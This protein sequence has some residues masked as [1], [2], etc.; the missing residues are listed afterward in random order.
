VVERRTMRYF[1]SVLFYGAVIVCC[2]P[3]LSAQTLVGNQPPRALS[4]CEVLESLSRHDRRMVVV[5]GIFR[6]THRHG[7]SLEDERGVQECPGFVGKRKYWTPA[8][9]LSGPSDPSAEVR[10][11]RN[12]AAEQEMDRLRQA[13]RLTAENKV[14]VTFEGLLQAKARFQ[15]FREPDG[16]VIGNGYGPDGTYA[17]CLVIRRVID[18]KVI[19]IKTGQ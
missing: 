19:K 17:A 15:V 7:S 11:G 16:E 18:S 13:A 10:F 8:L 4:V 2:V 5:T 3:L 1:E 6:H 9:C 14:I 12:L